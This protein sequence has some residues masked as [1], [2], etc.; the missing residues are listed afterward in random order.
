MA[1][2]SIIA[3]N[4]KMHKTVL[5]AVEL[6]NALVDST[7]R[8][9][10]VEIVVCPPFTALY[11]A[12]QA[13]AGEHIKLGAQNLFWEEKGA[14]T[15]QIAPGMLKDIGCKYVII[16]HSE[17]RGRFGTVDAELEKVLSY[18]SEADE[19][20]NRKVKAAF[21]AGIT[22]IVCCGELL[23]ERKGG[24]TDDVVRGQ[25]EADLAGMSSEQAASLVIAYEP[26]WAIGTGEVCDA[27]EANRV[28]GVIRETVREMFGSHAAESV[29][30]QYG[31]SVKPDNSRELL[32]QPEI[33]GALVGGAS[34]KA[35]DFTAIVKSA[36]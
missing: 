9:E 13:L 12:S 31:G 33:D 16:G 36:L 11:P 17:T 19:T 21:R 23:E 14:W 10:G 6:I 20:I 7:E 2:T 29:R 34:L 18:F 3:G 8:V 4:W 24:K 30:V 15:S 1:R 32:H 26:V 27:P 25:I 28:C 22:P 35:D 5:E